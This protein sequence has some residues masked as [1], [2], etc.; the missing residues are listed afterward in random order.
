[1][2][3]TSMNSIEICNTSDTDKIAKYEDLIHCCSES[4]H[5]SFD[6][7]N[8]ITIKI[9]SLPIYDQIYCLVKNIV[10]KA[11][12]IE[13]LILFYRDNINNSIQITDDCHKVDDEVDNSLVTLLQLFPSVHSLGLRTMKPSGTNA[14]LNKLRAKLSKSVSHDCVIINSVK[15]FLPKSNIKQLSLYIHFDKV[16]KLSDF[17]ASSEQINTITIHPRITDPFPNVTTLTIPIP[18]IKEISIEADCQ[19]IPVEMIERVL[20]LA[21]QA[22]AICFSN[23]LSTFKIA[24]VKYITKA[25]LEYTINFILFSPYLREL[26]FSMCH[27]CENDFEYL[28]DKL[29]DT[30]LHI[31][32][33]VEDHGYNYKSITCIANIIVNNKLLKE[34]TISVCRSVGGF[35]EIINVLATNASIE[36]FTMVVDELTDE[37]ISAL[38]NYVLSTLFE[39]LTLIDI[40]IYLKRDGSNHSTL[41]DTSS[42]TNRNNLSKTESRFV[43]T[44]A[45]CYN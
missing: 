19:E 5:F 1:M 12:N 28:S 23:S 18:K 42:I 20:K 21:P 8:H 24:S 9:K 43:K 45:I 39:N 29:H 32:G 27:L 10:S 30:D 4:P 44:R 17:I 37:E 15:Q 26:Y 14:L 16:I 3:S 11:K 13:S 41:I 33:F 35:F 25:V 40:C 38:S 31:I 7:I 6:N 34:V 22:S 36:K 2:E